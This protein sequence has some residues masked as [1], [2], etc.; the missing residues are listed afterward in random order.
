[1]LAGGTGVTGAKRKKMFADAK[2][3]N[4]NTA[5]IARKKK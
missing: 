2:K 4:Q 1:M 5:V 3:K